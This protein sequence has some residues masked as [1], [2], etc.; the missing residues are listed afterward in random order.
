MPRPT[1]HNLPTCQAFYNLL[2]ENPGII[3]IKFG[4]TWCNPCKMIENDVNFYFSK[5]PENVQCVLVDVDRS[6]EL[7]AYLKTKRML[8]G[9]PAI[10]CYYKG[11]TEHIPDE[12]VIGANK[13]QIK[14]LFTVCYQRAISTATA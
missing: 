4:A 7:Y 14:N 6:K 12:F 1:I 3:I 5:M 8:N 9:V 11:N 2:H 10:L 13:A